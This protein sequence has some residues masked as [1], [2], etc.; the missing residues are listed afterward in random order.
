MKAP[1]KSKIAIPI[2]ITMLIAIIALIIFIGY[3]IFND[4]YT[5]TPQAETEQTETQSETET[6]TETPEQTESVSETQSE[7]E[8]ETIT[9]SET[10][11]ETISESETDNANQEEAPLIVIDAG[12]QGPG[13]D[14]SQTEANGPGSS[15]MK[16]KLAVGTQGTTSGLYEYELNLEISLLLQR[17]LEARGYRVIMTRTTHD[18]DIGNIQRAQIANNANADA[19]IRIHANGSDDSNVN[20]AL[21]MSPSASNPYVSHLYDQCMYLSSCIINSYCTATGLNN[22][23]ISEVDDMTGIN[24]SQVPVTILEMGFMT[25]PGDDTYMADSA[26]HSAMVQGIANGIDIYFGRSS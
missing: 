12:H 9:E 22:A 25:N 24:W 19:L 6:Q 11:T 21:T 1:W 16:A 14:M 5:S 2:M 3:M 7:T 13:Q 10:Q 15:V 17:E 20:G 4:Y 8:T 18:T 26:N 23:G